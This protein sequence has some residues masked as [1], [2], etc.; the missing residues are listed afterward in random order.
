MAD[1]K[2]TKLVIDG[3]SYVIPTASATENG[4]MT[5]EMV[6]KLNGIDDQIS[7]AINDFATKVTDNATV[8][9]FKEI[10]DYV[11]ENKN[12]SADMVA[13]ISK[14]K[15]DVGKCQTTDAFNDWKAG[16]YAT[17]KANLEKKITD[18]VAGFTYGYD[19]ATQTLTLGGFT[20]KTA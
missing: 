13:D 3:N 17:D 7:G 11:A 6:T 5:P 14:L 10:V 18:A 9:T 12:G 8:D 2:F 4:L 1:L 16:E 15:E 19:A 20:Q